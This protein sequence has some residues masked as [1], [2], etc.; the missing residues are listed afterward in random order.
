VGEYIR[1]N[2]ARKINI[3]NTKI[4]KELGLQFTPIDQT[5]ADTYQDLL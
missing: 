2:I 3:N 5:L 1:T 4:I